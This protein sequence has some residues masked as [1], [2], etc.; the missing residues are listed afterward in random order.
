MHCIRF[1]LEDRPWS[2]AWRV[3]SEQMLI[4]ASYSFPA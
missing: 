4:M 3:A 1:M 2:L